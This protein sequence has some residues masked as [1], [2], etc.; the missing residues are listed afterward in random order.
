MK[1]RLMN[2][3]P[4]YVLDFIEANESIFESEEELQEALF[5]RDEPLIN[6][7][8]ALY[9][10]NEDVLCRLYESG[11]FD[12][13]TACMAGKAFGHYD[14]CQE[15][16]VWLGNKTYILELAK[17]SSVQFT[18]TTL[19]VNDEARL[20]AT[21]LS[22][23]EISSELLLLF[24]NRQWQFTGLSDSAHRYLLI[25][26]LHN[27]QPLL[28]DK[29]ECFR[30]PDPSQALW[31]LTEKLDVNLKNAALLTNLLE[32]CP[33][34]VGWPAA[35]IGIL[36]AAS[37]WFA[38]NEHE[39]LP[40]SFKSFGC[41]LQEHTSYNHYNFANYYE[42]LRFKIASQY[43]EYEDDFTK[44][45]ESNDRPIR[46]AFYE[47]CNY[48]FLLPPDSDKEK[49]EVD[50]IS[51]RYDRDGH[52]YLL[53]LKNNKE[54]DFLMLEGLLEK[55]AQC[56]KNNYQKDKSDHQKQALLE[57]FK[58]LYKDETGVDWGDRNTR[59][60]KELEERNK[61]ENNELKNPKAIAE[62]QAEAN[63][64]KYPIILLGIII[65]IALVLSKTN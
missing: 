1:Y 32:Q 4:E 45:S 10:N 41:S 57:H 14:Y 18:D 40:K 20:L 58:K 25:D 26:M 51:K 33:L 24:I 28:I 22:N 19:Q 50:N 30:N 52:Y 62:L 55:L 21:L 49:E 9:G 43:P 38:P 34:V 16:E 42:W 46:L 35:S 15:A 39:T 61:K 27:K 17:E 31:K 12:L 54:V 64:K 7:A 56:A 2:S 60:Q 44:L 37:R 5:Q 8:L 36:Q 23:P 63:I 59:E 29:E 65:F 47:R 11:N 53:A 3:S 48:F 6:L 13:Q